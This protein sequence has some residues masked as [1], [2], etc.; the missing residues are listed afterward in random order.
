M[1]TEDKFITQFRRR[2]FNII[3]QYRLL[4]KGDA[5][6]VGVS[7]G[8]DSVCLLHLLHTLSSNLDIKLFAVHINHM[9]RGAEADADEQYTED[10]CKKLG[11]PLFIVKADVKSIAKE[12]GMSFEE[13]GRE[14]RYREFEKYAEILGASKIAVAHNRN[15]QAET[16]MMHIIRGTGLGGL[17]GME[18]RRGPIIRPLLGVGREDIEKYCRYAGLNPRTDSTNLESD[19]TRNRIRLELFPYIDEKFGANIVESLLRLSMHSAGDNSY[20]GQCAAEAYKKSMEEKEEGLV[21]LKLDELRKLHSAILV[22]VF[23]LAVADVAG[24]IDGIGSVHYKA[25]SRL[26]EK[27]TTGMQA[28]L[29]GG[30]RAAVSYGHIKIRSALAETAKYD[31]QET[32]TFE[33]SIV[34]PGTTE[35]YELNAQIKSSIYS[36]NAV[37]KNI[38]MGYN[39]YVQF[40]DYD[41]L[42]RGIH[43]RN[44]RDGDIFKPF[45]STGSKKLKKYFIDS[46]IPR[47]TRGKIPLVCI[48]N[49]VVWIIGYKISDKF[50]VTENTRSIL[51]L[52][53]IRRN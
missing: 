13:A 3:E 5:V 11:V 40:F 10:L 1:S 12:K 34:I 35:I 39:S 47:E 31:K 38:R 43:I 15:D 32:V 17:S 2:I 50:K 48:G 20:L 29:P 18:F 22:R 25:L 16:V 46:K 53:Y 42:S 45:G 44:R 30:L 7:G 8:P 9:L 4:D 52:E 27:G 23:R 19:Y 49:E 36:I 24:D 33:K 37:D 41:S 6:V 14:V 28:E 21:S 51:K 26:V